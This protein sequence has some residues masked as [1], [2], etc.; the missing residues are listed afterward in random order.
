MQLPVIKKMTGDYSLSQLKEAEKALVE[1]EKPAI[2]IDGED[3]GEQLTHVLAAIWIIE[4]MNDGS[5]TPFNKAMREYTQ[6]VR[7]SITS[8]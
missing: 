8:G 1:E 7:T 3:E 5:G 6:K 2:D 4:K